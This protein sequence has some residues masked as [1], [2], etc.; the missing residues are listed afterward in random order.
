MF[1]TISIIVN[2]IPIPVEKY[3]LTDFDHKNRCGQNNT[4]RNWLLYS[5]AR[6]DETNEDQK[7][8]MLAEIYILK[9]RQK[10]KKEKWG[11]IQELEKT[12]EGKGINIRIQN[13]RRENEADI[14]ILRSQV[15]L[16]RLPKLYMEGGLLKNYSITTIAIMTPML[17]N[18]ALQ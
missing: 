14:H 3:E 12:E 9:K 17:H 6:P 8:E 2:L 10:E 13:R 16:S 5:S 7:G 4:E 1:N 18:S 15:E 11:R